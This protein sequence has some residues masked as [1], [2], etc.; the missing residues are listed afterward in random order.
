MICLDASANL[1]E[2]LLSKYNLNPKKYWSWVNPMGF[3]IKKTEYKIQIEN[4]LHK[5]AVK[6]LMLF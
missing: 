6:N 4:F 5:R 1:L 3:S 2:T